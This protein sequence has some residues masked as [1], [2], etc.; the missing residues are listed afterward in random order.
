M[1]TGTS[2]TPTLTSLSQPSGPIG[3]SVTVYGSGFTP[4]GSV[5]ITFGG[6]SAGTVTANGNG[7]IST[8]AVTVP[9]GLSATQVQV[10]AFDVT[11][12]KYAGNTLSFTITGSAITP[13]LTTVTPSSAAAGQNVTVSGSGFTDNGSVLVYFGTT[14]V[15]SQVLVADANGN[16]TN[17]TV[18]V[19]TM[20]AGLTTVGATDL[21]SGAKTATLTFTVTGATTGTL[22]LSPVSGPPSVSGVLTTTVTLSFAGGTLGANQPVTVFFTDANNNGPTQLTPSNPNTDLNGNYSGTVVI[23]TQAA[24][25]TPRSY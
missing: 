7:Q 12:Q 25:G 23:P 13:T 16:L 20:A 21:G 1:V 15:A 8:T 9:S 10:S 6:V 11:A 17:Q 3:T 2:G 19:P 4:S 14:N 5:Q 24:G 18:T 22:T